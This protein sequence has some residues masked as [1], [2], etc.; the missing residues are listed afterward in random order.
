VLHQIGGFEAI[1]LIAH[2]GELTAIL[3]IKNA[4]ELSPK[5]VV[6]CD[7]HISIMEAFIHVEKLLADDHSNS[8][9]LRDVAI[10]CMQVIHTLSQNPITRLAVH[11]AEQSFGC[12]S[13]AVCIITASSE[14]HN[15][16]K[17]DTTS[18]SKNVTE[19]N[20]KQV[21][22]LQLGDLVYA[23]SIPSS[24]RSKGGS[25]IDKLEGKVAFIGPVKFKPGDNN[26]WIGIQ[27]T[28]DSAGQGKCDGS[29]QGV[30][31]FDCDG[32]KKDGIFVKKDKVIKKQ[33][34]Q[35]LSEEAVSPEITEEGTVRH[36]LLLKDDLTLE[37]AAFLLLLSLS[38][39]Q[40]HRDAMMQ[41]INFVDNL[42]IM[43]ENSSAVIGYR[44]NALE[45][46]VS[47]TRHL[48]KK[49]DKLPP[50]LYVLVESQMKALQVTRDK[51]E[52]IERKQLICMAIDG[53]QNLFGSFMDPNEQ[54]RTMKITSD[55]F[56]YLT[57]SLYTGPKSK[58][59]A[60]SIE[61]GHLFYQLSSFFIY[62]L[63]GAESVMTS[64]LS[65]K[66]ISS[67][68]RYIMMTASV[69]SFDRN[70][71]IAADMKLAGGEYWNAALVHCLFYISCNMTQSS[72][73]HIK[74]SYEQ[75]IADVEP[76]PMYFQFCLEHITKE[77]VVASVAARQ[78]LANLY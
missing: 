52:Q 7:A 25:K 44:I 45:L 42:T 3:A 72:Q 9:R 8:S 19:S 12:L 40:P 60:V 65:V 50:L 37:R 61:D 33:G 49:D 56:I 39:S 46:L 75:L 1:G 30:R 68:I 70:I 51:R 14:F 64:I 69:P 78:I 55:L 41:N 35:A 77:K 23:D 58:R 11:S 13:A 53:L 32:R 34:N 43:I 29:V 5:S 17:K 66:F 6:D 24:K 20:E 31:Y 26:D 71:P 48:S 76:S 27:L 22:L 36:P 4:C 63:G 38:T 21:D 74:M 47:L 54:S 18:I 73:E 57:D 28:G 15:I 2:E 59:V 62:S 10:S 67:M 16:A